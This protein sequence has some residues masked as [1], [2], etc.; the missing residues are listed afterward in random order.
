M[1][2]DCRTRRRCSTPFHFE[3]RAGKCADQ[4]TFVFVGREWS[5]ECL[6]PDH[7]EQVVIISRLRNSE[8]VREKLLTFAPIADVKMQE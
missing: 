5:I 6:V 3:N 8:D 1:A 7:T 2:T 4:L